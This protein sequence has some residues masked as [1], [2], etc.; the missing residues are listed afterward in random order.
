[1]MN[2]QIIFLVREP[3]DPETWDPTPSTSFLANHNPWQLKSAL[4]LRAKYEHESANTAVHT[5][6]LSTA[7][8]SATECIGGHEE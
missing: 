2:M 8:Q 5:P 3:V 4:G 6:R 1:M 7:Q